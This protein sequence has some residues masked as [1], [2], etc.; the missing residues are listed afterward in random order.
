MESAAGWA[1]EE[2][3]DF[4]QSRLARFLHWSWQRYVVGMLQN[5]GLLFIDWSM[6]KRLKY[7]TIKKRSAK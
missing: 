6:E 3:F 5:R 7:S 2:L 1:A 4:F